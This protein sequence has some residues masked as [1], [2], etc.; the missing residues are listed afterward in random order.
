MMKVVWIVSGFVLLLLAGCL[1][2]EYRGDDCLRDEHF[3]MKDIPYVF[4]GKE[5]VDYRPY[6]TFVEQ[7]DLFVFSEQRLGQYASYNFVY[8]REH[9]VITREV[10]DNRR[11]ALFVANLY[12]PKELQ[13]N[14]RT[15]HLEAVFSILDYEEPPVLLAAITDI[16]S[17]RDSVPVELRLM[18]SRLEIHL[19]N[20]PSWL[21]GLDVRVHNIA[22]TVSTDYVLGDTTHIHKALFFD[23]QGSGTYLF[24]VNTFPTY[25]GKAALLEITPLGMSG[26]APILVEDESLHFLPGVITRME[27]VYDADEKITISIRSDDKW[28]VMDGGSIII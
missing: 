28:E 9:P 6:Y 25:S 18:V 1:R 26:T 22:G 24:G 5:A 27:M 17:R 14:F 12:S 10:D 2:E 4:V 11:D 23:H 8:C 20:P 15:G 3:V 16:A 13:W 21:V 19:V 7:L